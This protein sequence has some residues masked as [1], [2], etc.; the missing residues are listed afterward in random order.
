MK[1]FFALLI[2]ITSFIFSFSQDSTVADPLT[3]TVPVVVDTLPITNPADLIEETENEQK[4]KLNL[5]QLGIANRSKDHIL[6]QIGIDNW[7]KMPDSIKTKGISRSFSM[8]LMF[9][10]PFKTNPKLSVAIG[11]GVSTSNIYF[12][13]TYIDITGRMANTLSFN[14]VSDTVHF[15][16]YKLLTSF[17]EAPVELRYVKNPAN[18]KKSFKAALGGKIGLLVAAGTKG[19]TLQNSSDATINAFIQKEKSKRYFNT[20][21]I[22]ATGR[23]G[24]GN[25]SVFGSYQVNAF[26]KEGFGPD[27]RPYSVGLTLSGL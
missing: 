11:A 27:V 26:I 21:R 6:I 23:V 13:E 7:A 22:S 1:K 16:K 24:F 3:D 8:Y 17:V 25:L 15:K 20:T 2:S 4:K 18:P 12:S 5:A 19:K 14:D 9:D 10:F